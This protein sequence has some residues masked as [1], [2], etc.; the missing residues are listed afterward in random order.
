MTL[1]PP[2]PLLPA[3][4]LDVAGP[5]GGNDDG[6]TGAVPVPLKDDSKTLYMLPIKELLRLVQIGDVDEVKKWIL[7]K[8]SNGKWRVKEVVENMR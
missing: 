3:L 8:G 6:G 5:S 4:A 1:P 2:K 7:E